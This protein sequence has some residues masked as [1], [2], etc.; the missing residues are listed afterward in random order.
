MRGKLGEERRRLAIVREDF[1]K[2]CLSSRKL[3]RIEL[4]EWVEKCPCCVE[5]GK[6][7]G[8]DLVEIFDFPDDGW[9]I[10]SAILVFGRIFARIKVVVVRDITFHRR[11]VTVRLAVNS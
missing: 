3:R 6:I 4:V 11:D 7:Y 5:L 8:D 10:Q 9:Y 1:G 2:G